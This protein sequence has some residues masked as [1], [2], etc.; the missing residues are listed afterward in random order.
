[1]L[2]HVVIYI[3]IAI[4][5]VGYLFLGKNLSRLC[6]YFNIILNLLLSIFTQSSSILLVTILLTILV[7]TFPAID[8]YKYY[9]STKSKNIRL[10]IS[11]S[12]SILFLI[13]ILTPYDD[14]LVRFKMVNSGDNLQILMIFILA[15]Y[16]LT[17]KDGRNGKIGHH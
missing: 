15:I 13:L 2:N 5:L 6:F 3:F 11:F 12:I 8:D 16:L 4:T 17:K 10:L 9:R 7:E 1:M 14:L